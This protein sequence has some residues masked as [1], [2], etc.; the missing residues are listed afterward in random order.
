MLTLLSKESKE[1][2]IE[3]DV[4]SIS[5]V[6]LEMITI[7]EEGEELSLEDQNRQESDPIPIEATN[8]ELEKIIDFCRLYKDDPFRIPDKSECPSYSQEALLTKG[9]SVYQTDITKY[10]P[11]WCVDYIKQIPRMKLMNILLISDQYNIFPLLHLLA[12]HFATLCV[13]FTDNKKVSEIEECRRKIEV[14]KIL[15]RPF[16]EYKPCDEC[17]VKYPDP[18]IAEYK[19]C[20]TCINSWKE[21]IEAKK[22]VFRAEAA[23][24]LKKVIEEKEAANAV[25]G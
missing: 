19:P 16:D 23:E 9:Y 8:Y 1:Y 21:I 12:L 14:N 10:V 20:E 22:N 5:R 3:R 6:I 11:K 7:N 25:K 18:E 17:L 2:K 15:F 24:Y 13:P 4:I